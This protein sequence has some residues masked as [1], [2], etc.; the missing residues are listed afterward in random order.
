MQSFGCYSFKWKSHQE[1]SCRKSCQQQSSLSFL[2]LQL[3][4]SCFSIRGCLK[5]SKFKFKKFKR[6]FLWQND[7]KWESCQ[8]QS[9]ITFL[10]LQLWFWSSFHATLFYQLKIWISKNI[11]LKQHF[12]RV[13]DLS[14]KSHEHTSCT[15]HQDL[16]LLF[17]SSFH[18]TLF[19]DF[20]IW[21]SKNVNLKR[22]FKR[23]NDF[24]WKT[25]EC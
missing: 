6:S 25:H 16:Q 20:K 22:H 1:Q 7:F 3:Y 2:D 18:V 24:S 23:V 8:L 19:Y 12:P 14:W 5:N 17:W 11:N 4:F 9:S 21:I 10:D 13:T 15:T